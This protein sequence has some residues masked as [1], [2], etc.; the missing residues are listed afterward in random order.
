M[1]LPDIFNGPFNFT[2]SAEIVDEISKG[3]LPQFN[4]MYLEYY[5]WTEKGV[6]EL[7]VCDDSSDD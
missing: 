5:Y 3:N 2:T 6:Y 7:V 1:N 4:F